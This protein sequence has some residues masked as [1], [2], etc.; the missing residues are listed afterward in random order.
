MYLAFKKLDPN[1][2]TTW[3]PSDQVF[4]S[5]VQIA[6]QLDNR[7]L[8]AYQKRLL[9]ITEYLVTKKTTTLKLESYYQIIIDSSRYVPA[10]ELCEVPGYEWVLLPVTAISDEYYFLYY[11]MPRRVCQVN[12]IQD[13]YN[14]YGVQIVLDLDIEKTFLYY[15]PERWLRVLKPK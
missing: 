9:Q 12:L 7:F 8:L 3:N 13:A 11:K 5:S 4:H 10:L 14:D 15:Q 1:L 2:L 6:K